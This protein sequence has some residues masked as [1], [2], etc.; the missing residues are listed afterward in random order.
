MN[1]NILNPHPDAN[2][3]SLAYLNAPPPGTNP[4]ETPDPALNPAPA[5][6]QLRNRA[7]PQ[8]PPLSPKQDL[9]DVDTGTD[10]SCSSRDTSPDHAPGRGLKRT[11]PDTNDA[12]TLEHSEPMCKQ[13]RTGSPE[14]AI[15]PIHLSPEATQKALLE[16]VTQ[17]KLDRLQSLVNQTEDIEHIFDGDLWKVAATHGHLAVIDWL[18][19]HA[20]RLDLPKP[21]YTRLFEIAAGNGQIDILRWL[22]KMGF[23]IRR[24]NDYDN[25]ALTLATK[26]GHL[27]IVKYLAEQGDDIQ[28]VY[29]FGDNALI[30]AAE[31]GHLEVVRWLAGQG[32]NIQQVDSGGDNAL[33]LAAYGGHLEVVQWLAGQGCNIQQVDSGGNNALTLAAKAGHLEVVQYLAEKGL[34]I[35]QVNSNGYTAL[36]L[37]M[38]SEHSAIACD[39]IMRGAN[40]MIGS[41]PDSD[42]Y[43]F[44]ALGI[45]DTVLINMMIPRHDVSKR[46]ESGFTPLMIAAK[47]KLIEVAVPLIRA[48]MRVPDGRALVQEAYQIDTDPLF[49]ELLNNPS[50]LDEDPSSYSWLSP[51]GMPTIQTSIVH[52]YVSSQYVVPW[53]LQSQLGSGQSMTPLQKKSAQAGILAELPA[54]KLANRIEKIFSR[55]LM[56]SL[57][58]IQKRVA[59]FISDDIDVLATQANGW[60]E[61]HLV[62]VIEHLYPSC[63][64]HSF[65]TRPAVGIIKELADKGLYYPIARRIASA[66]TTAWAAMS[67]EAK[68]VLLSMPT[69]QPDDWDVEYLP[70]PE[71]INGEVV[72]WPDTL[73]PKLDG[74]VVTPVGVRLLQ[75]FRVALKDELDAVESRILYAEDEYLAPESDDLYADLMMRQLHLVAQFWRAELS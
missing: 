56:P 58:P 40:L 74:F 60:E 53:S 3:S 52:Y 55:K 43:L 50:I 23:V 73:A 18:S 57:L 64:M 69:A 16:A 25:H 38:D 9:M 48:T 7:Q 13:R 32:C 14:P 5:T 15:P 28:Q 62:P 41:P 31:A 46:S 45:G 59:T 21:D 34:D 19:R 30:L 72:I 12:E 17:G 54:W 29:F 71:I 61:D 68:P 22:A 75:A 39:L 26:A 2:S 24:V 37:S 11:R 51:E 63:L 10:T 27:E 65:S 70:D 35:N 42:G 33:T 36:A 49:K 66:W 1:P 4:A 47:N 20:D 8:R 44:S 6:P 67:E